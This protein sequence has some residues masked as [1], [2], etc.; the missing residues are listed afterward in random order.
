VFKNKGF[1]YGLGLGLI[2]GASLL[3]L[4]N[5]A[6]LGNP[7]K[8]NDLPTASPTPSISPSPSASPKS[9]IAPVTTVKPTVTAAIPA[10]PGSP[11]ATVTAVTKTVEPSA[12]TASEP[13]NST[14]IIE[15]G[16]TSSEV[17]T[18]LYEKGIISDRITF[19]DSLSHLKLDRVIRAGT[20][21]F[22]PNEKDSEIIDIITIRR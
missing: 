3:Q 18:L 8:T 13:S 10:T 14:V 6:M 20:Y 5:F 4:M 17:A 9:S 12:P 22:L 2:L 1:L 15:K 7:T 21:T 19:D 11:T 16:M